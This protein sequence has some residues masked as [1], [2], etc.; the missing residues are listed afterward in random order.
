VASG[1]LTLPTGGKDLTFERIGGSWR[2]SLPFLAGERRETVRQ[3]VG[4]IAP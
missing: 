3:P 2:V 1:L 4:A